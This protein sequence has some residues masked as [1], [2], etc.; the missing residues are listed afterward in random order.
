MASPEELHAIHFVST[1]TGLK[2]KSRALPAKRYTSTALKDR[3]R[4]GL[5]GTS[6]PIDDKRGADGPSADASSSYGARRDPIIPRPQPAGSSPWVS[7]PAPNGGPV[8]S[9]LARRLQAARLARRMSLKDLSEVLREAPR[10]TVLSADQLRAF[11]VGAEHVQSRAVLE[12]LAAALEEPSLLRHIMP[13]PGQRTKPTNSE[14]PS[15][16]DRTSS[17]L[18]DAKMMELER[19]ID[20]ERQLVRECG[21]PVVPEDDRNELKRG[22]LSETRLRA[23]KQRAHTRIQECETALQVVSV[24]EFVKQLHDASV[25][26]TLETV[27]A[28]HNRI[29][30]VG[31]GLLA[32]QLPPSITTLDLS[33][34]QISSM[35]LKALCDAACDPG[36]ASIRVLELSGNRLAFAHAPRGSAAPLN[37]V[38]KSGHT[39]DAE[40]ALAL[41]RLLSKSS[42]LRE[43][44]LAYC[45]LGESTLRVILGGGVDAPAAGVA[46]ASSLE[47]L[48]LSGNAL[49]TARASLV[50]VSAL[51]GHPIQEQQSISLGQLT[52]LDMTCVGMGDDGA[53]AISD[54]LLDGCA[55]TDLTLN[56]NSIGQNG[57]AALCVHVLTNSPATALSIRSDTMLVSLAVPCCAFP[58]TRY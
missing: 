36:F 40:G 12:R 2:R 7:R 26:G 34:N 48:N 46:S 38:A 45:G 31:A 57:A 44:G 25:S 27:R 47:A 3:P 5:T 8:Q 37:G 14:Q 6:G 33:H 16:I 19:M 49:G 54:A 22:K 53:A 39:E 17:G 9:E 10:P 13:S 21:P 30:D 42:A 43:L 32:A 51:R 41:Y 20:R 50:L 15:E 55:L 35:G 18:D 28:G 11:E 4:A 52:K 58:F 24:R 23:L 56:S 1:V 29:G